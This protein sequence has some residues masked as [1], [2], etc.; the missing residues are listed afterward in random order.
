MRQY[1][2]DAHKGA[3]E[4]MIGRKFFKYRLA[5]EADAYELS[6]YKY[7]AITPFFMRNNDLKIILSDLI[8]KDLD[9]AFFYLGGGRVELKLGVSVEE[10][11][12]YFG[13]RVIVGSISTN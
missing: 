11:M 2:K 1:H 10:F 6:G 5:D 8:V 12:G 13:E 4:K 3:K 9:P 7:N